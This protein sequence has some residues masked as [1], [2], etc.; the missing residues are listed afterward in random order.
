M[1]WFPQSH[2]LDLMMQEE[3]MTKVK[4]YSVMYTYKQKGK[5]K[6]EGVY[7]DLDY[8]INQTLNKS[9]MRLKAPE[10]CKT[11]NDVA[12]IHSQTHPPFI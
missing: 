9:L 8:N 4:H 3:E 10:L 1:W 6:I 7:R 2:T 12:Y 5:V 11:K